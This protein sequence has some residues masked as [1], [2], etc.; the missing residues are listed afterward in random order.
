MVIEIINSKDYDLVVLGIGMS[1]FKELVL[2]SMSIKVMHHAKCH[3]MVV[4]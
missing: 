1:V 2:G 4:R 3:V